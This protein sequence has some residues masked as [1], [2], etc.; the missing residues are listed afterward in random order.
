MI[1]PQKSKGQAK[2]AAP[3]APL[4]GQLRENP[5]VWTP[6][7]DWREIYPGNRGVNRHG[8]YELYDAPVGVHLKVEEALKSDPLIISEQRWEGGGGLHALAVWKEGERFHMLYGSYPPKLPRCLRYAVSEDG[9]H[10]TR[11]ELGQVDFNGS[12]KNNALA[13]APPA[14]GIF[15]DP[16]APPDE[17]FKAIA[18]DGGAFDPDT[19]EKLPAEEW[20]KRRKAQDYEGTAYKGPRMVFR[21]WVSGWTSPDGTHWKKIREP[22][23]DFP[24]DGGIAPGYDQETSHYFAYIRIHGV[25]PSEP[26]GIGSGVPEVG[27]GRRSI[28]FTK[29]KDF[30]H[31][32][33]P[34]LV[35]Y[36]DPQDASDV[37]FYGGNYFPYPGRKDLH[38]MFVQIYHQ[39]TDHGDMQ[40][41]FSH[42]GLFWYRPERRAI[43]PVGPQGSGEDCMV[44]SWG[45]GLIEL[46]DGY[47]ATLYDATSWLHNAGETMPGGNGQI[48]WA[49]WLPHRLCGLEAANEGQFTIQTIIRT[50]K[51]LRL[52]YRCAPG[53]WVKTE[54][55][56]AIPSRLNP[57]G[58]GV[59]G[60]TFEECDR[61]TGD[62]LDQVVTWQG[63]SDISAVGETV[64]IR[65]KMFQAKVF[66]YLV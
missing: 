40:I 49:R 43:I 55:I 66:A 46:P 44:Y 27:A 62:S 5:G 63:K 41:A 31:W 22:L 54:L 29:T 52:N 14:S 12:K 45:G 17:R 59:P 60:F 8:I 35:L 9:Y 3:G 34:K 11:P 64:A 6:F 51:E 56:S 2:K 7:V 57:D 19:G 21:N 15:Q 33:P 53:G 42:D 25:P 58:E 20:Q 61:L 23:A 18:M 32:P 4:R 30:R 10:W 1:D 26:K 16:Q 50:K 38:G 13:D 47:W 36:P 28:G 24:A 48:R 37:S 39:I 65:L